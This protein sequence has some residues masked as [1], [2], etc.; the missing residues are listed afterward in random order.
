MCMHS[1]RFIFYFFFPAALNEDPTVCLQTCSSLQVLS[2]SLPMELLQRSEHALLQTDYTVCEICD[3][4]VCVC[5][6]RCVD[7]CRV[8]LVHSTV[9]VRQ[10]FGKLLR[11]VPLHMAL[12]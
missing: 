11:S 12:R 9:R 4:N 3:L 7:V 1:R 6:C 10:A 5:T 8:Q 2:S